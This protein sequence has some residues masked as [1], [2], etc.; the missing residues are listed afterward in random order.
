MAIITSRHVTSTWSFYMEMCTLPQ[1]A[2]HSAHISDKRPVVQV[3]WKTVQRGDDGCTMR[4]LATAKS[5]KPS[6]YW[7]VLLDGPCYY[8]V[9]MS[10]FSLMERSES[11]RYY[12]G[13]HVSEF[14]NMWPAVQK[15]RMRLKRKL[16]SNP[17]NVNWQSPENWKRFLCK[18]H[19]GENINVKLLAEWTMAIRISHV[20]ST[21]MS[22][23]TLWIWHLKI[24]SPE[25]GTRSSAMCDSTS[26]LTHLHGTSRFNHWYPAGSWV[27]SITSHKRTNGEIISNCFWTSK[28]RTAVFHQFI[29]D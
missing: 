11:L 3:A 2:S 23:K 21:K 10:R 6:Y 14:P 15:W 20:P 29:V 26:V 8:G 16:L 13:A 18:I 24:T 4:G 9:T 1:T 22:V 7:A 12:Y 17:V 28:L 25:L 27:F 5:V 19:T